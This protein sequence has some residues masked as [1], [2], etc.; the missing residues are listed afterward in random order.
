MA[1][2]RYKF[3]LASTILFSIVDL[4]VTTVIYGHG[5][6]YRR[7]FLKD[8]YLYKFPLSM[9]ELWVF[10]LARTSILLGGSLG[11]ICKPN[12]AVDR[13]S[14]VKPLMSMVLVLMWLYTMT[15]L[16]A[17]TEEENDLKKPWFWSLFCWTHVGLFGVS[18]FWSRIAKIKPIKPKRQGGNINVNTDEESLIENSSNEGGDEES[19]KDENDSEENT[20]SVKT[21]WKLLRLSFPDWYIVL[22]GFIF[23]TLSS[24]GKLFFILIY[25]AINIA[26]PLE[27]LCR[28][29]FRY[30]FR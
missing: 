3:L 5:T 17:F 12:A 2:S 14:C 4:V 10:A 8:F 13:F 22:T 16:L 23:M 11:F 7:Q 20:S 21:I 28:N 9:I 29:V 24:A 27:I 6:D 26:S 1:S 25:I 30:Q 15:K 19:G 18:I